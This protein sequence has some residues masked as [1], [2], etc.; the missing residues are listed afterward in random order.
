MKTASCRAYTHARTY[1][2]V[3]VRKVMEGSSR[4]NGD[5]KKRMEENEKCHRQTCDLE[6]ERTCSILV[7]FAIENKIELIV[8]VPY[9]RRRSLDWNEM[10]RRLELQTNSG[11]NFQALLPCALQ[12]LNNRHSEHLSGSIDGRFLTG[13]LDGFFSLWHC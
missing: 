1:V 8:G 3:L 4:Q 6:I 9:C 12:L 11:F 5:A 10:K 2:H 7:F 13:W